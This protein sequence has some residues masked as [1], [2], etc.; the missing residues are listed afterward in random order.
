MSRLTLIHWNAAE[1]EERAACL[2]SVG[3]ETN[4]YAPQGAPGIRA[5]RKNPPDAFV[6]DLSRL[7]SQGCGVAIM[8][9]QQQ[10]TRPIPIVFAG[11][12]PGKV[13]RVR[14]L[15]PDAVYAEWSRIH[16]ALRR[17]LEEPPADPV[18]PGTMDPYSGAPLPKRLGI[19][20]GSEVVL[21]GAPAGFEEK[22]GA[23]PENVR[24]RRRAQ[25]RAHVL[26][27]FT[28]SR[29]DLDRRFPVAARALA[30]GGG[31]WIV[32]PKKAS[33][34]ATDLT[35]SAVRAFGLGAGFVDYKICA[36]DGTWSGLLFARRRA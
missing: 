14:E 8:L 7:P 1:G 9:R 5:L 32:W 19:Q 18:V 28:R 3:H 11:G 20:A 22:L 31:L 25:G 12:D 23:L 36:I 4:A 13:A 21:L 15:L 34:V 10:A 29:A 33:G 2:R 24:L 16:D 27:L 17:A 30:E 6:I 26:L 35:Q